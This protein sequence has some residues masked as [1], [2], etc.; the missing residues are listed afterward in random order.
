MGKRVRNRPENHQLMRLAAATELELQWRGRR[1]VR[2]AH[3]VF[4]DARCVQAPQAEPEGVGAGG[5]TQGGCAGP[6]A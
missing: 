1:I 4:D 3:L 2:R 5:Q 6:C